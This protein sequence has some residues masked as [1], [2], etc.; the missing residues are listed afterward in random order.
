MSDSAFSFFKVTLLAEYCVNL[1]LQRKEEARIM[2]TSA[3]ILLVAVLVLS[4]AVFTFAQEA[5]WKE[6]ISKV[7]TLYQQGR[8]SEAANV[9][10]E[11][12]AVAEKT[13][14]P[15][16]PDVAISLDNLA[17]VYQAQG[18]YSEAESLH[19]RALGIYEKALRPDHPHVATVCENMAEL[20]RQIGKEDEAEKL[21]ARARRI[22]AKR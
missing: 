4:F 14:D 5:Q 21:E 11:A 9:A 15:D 20:C 8:H 17:M 2:R 12:L 19:K 6:L 16:H 7:A 22:R 1:A 13:F 10:E 18:R 3:Q